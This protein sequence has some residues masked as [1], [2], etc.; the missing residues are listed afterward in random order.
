MIH[1]SIW[2]MPIRGAQRMPSKR[3]MDEKV[4][5]MTVLEGFS[6][7]PHGAMAKVR[8]EGASEKWP[9]GECDVVFSDTSLVILRIPKFRKSR[10]P[11]LG[12]LGCAGTSR[13]VSLF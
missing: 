9:F 11:I 3:P 6:R 8:L 2:R 7:G 10:Y 13:N 1:V 5:I 12:P 4:D